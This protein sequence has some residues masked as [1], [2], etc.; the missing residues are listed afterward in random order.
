MLNTM[1]ADKSTAN[2]T[3]SLTEAAEDS[4]DQRKQKSVARELKLCNHAC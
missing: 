2:R 3:T 1:L 4:N